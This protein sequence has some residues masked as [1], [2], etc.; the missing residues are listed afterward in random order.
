M[1]KTPYLKLQNQSASD[2]QEDDSNTP[3][4]SVNKQGR[5]LMSSIRST[6]HE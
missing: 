6:M 2:I 3:D 4:G 1:R 5:T